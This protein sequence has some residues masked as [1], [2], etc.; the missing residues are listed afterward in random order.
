MSMGSSQKGKFSW[1]LL[2]CT[3]IAIPF[4]EDTRRPLP[5]LSHNLILDFPA[6]RT[7]KHEFL[8]FTDYLESVILQD[9]TD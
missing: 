4:W 1:R 2:V 6:S 7:V 5:E 3:C 9:K 8:F